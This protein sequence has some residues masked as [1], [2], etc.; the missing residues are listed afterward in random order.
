MALENLDLVELINS[1]TESPIEGTIGFGSCYAF[2]STSPD[3]NEGESN[4]DSSLIFPISKN[5]AILAVADGA[6]GMQAGYKASKIAI[7]S[8]KK[9]IKKIE[10]ASEDLRPYI[11]DSFE[12][13][14]EK[15]LQEGFGGMTTLLVVEI[16]PSKFRTY[17][18]GDSS[19]ISISSH[20][21]IKHQTVSHAPVDHAISSGLISEIEGLLHE[22][23][24]LVSN[25]VGSKEM[26]IEIGPWVELS[27]LDTL[28]MGSDG[29][30]DNLM[31]GQISE[32]MRKGKLDACFSELVDVCTKNMHID[33]PNH[34]AKMDDLTIIT[35]RPR[36]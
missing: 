1:D 23:R 14:N 28:V 22:D 10:S 6:G 2:T 27:A 9:T 3:R 29:L 11:I 8:L 19:L 30:F 13:A 33:K 35:F 36:D 5:N 21:N 26:Y 31:V 32:I 18:V 7:D 17:H 20:G 12:K 15:I 16:E 4:E 34:P 24:H 25:L